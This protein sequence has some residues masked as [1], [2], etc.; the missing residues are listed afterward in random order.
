MLYQLV[1]IIGASAEIGSNVWYRNF[2]Y[3][4]FRYHTSLKRSKI[5]Q[6]EM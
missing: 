6:N 2:R 1:D 4:N 5:G 3:R